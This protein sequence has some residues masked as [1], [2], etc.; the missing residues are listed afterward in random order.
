MKNNA[1][2]SQGAMKPINQISPWDLSKKN[3]NY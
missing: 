2:K 1:K 3:G